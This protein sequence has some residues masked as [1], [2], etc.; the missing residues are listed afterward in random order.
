[1]LRSVAV[2]LVLTLSAFG[3]GGGGAEAREAQNPVLTATQN[4]RGTWK[5][6]SFKP[7][8]PLEPPIQSFVD[9]QLSTL[10][11]TIE[12]DLYTAMGAGIS[13]NG[14]IHIRG[15][16]GDVV[17]GTLY[18][19]MG[20]AHPVSGRFVGNQFHFTAQS[21]QWQGSGVLERTGN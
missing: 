12:G 6:V 1:M 7:V 9:A 15:V 2:A 5:L 11:I 17:L 21:A 14:R 3:C 8:T 18:D 10:T 19:R 20:A 4:L 13:T 16:E